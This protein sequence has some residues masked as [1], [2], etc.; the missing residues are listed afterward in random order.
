LIHAAVG[1]AG[2]RLYPIPDYDVASR[3]DAPGPMGGTNY[4]EGITSVAAA[5]PIKRGRAMLKT[6]V[7][8]LGPGALLV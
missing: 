5:R 3:I 2:G 7:A 6:R 4:A 8:S 1:S